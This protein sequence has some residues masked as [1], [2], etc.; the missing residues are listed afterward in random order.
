[1]FTTASLDYKT[2]PEFLFIPLSSII[3]FNEFSDPKEI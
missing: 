1:M 2:L 3:K